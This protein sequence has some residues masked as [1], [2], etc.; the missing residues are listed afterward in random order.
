MDPAT[1]VAIVNGINSI[2]RVSRELGVN[3]SKFNEL[4]SKADEEG[5]E[6]TVEELAALSEDSQD[7][8]DNLASATRDA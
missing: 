8:I 2:L 5:R 3:I 1:L 6:I 7:A 4:I